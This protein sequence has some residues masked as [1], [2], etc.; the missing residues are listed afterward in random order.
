MIYDGKIITKIDRQRR[1]VHLSNEKFIRLPWSS[2]RL[3]SGL[4]SNAS[5]ADPNVSGSNGAGQG[6]QR[7]NVSESGQ[8]NGSSVN[9]GGRLGDAKSSEVPRDHH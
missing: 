2:A 3:L 6:D 1:R 5:G 7:P 4:G 8:G 9:L